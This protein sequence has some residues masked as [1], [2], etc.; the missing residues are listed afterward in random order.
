[1]ATKLCAGCL[2][3]KE[4]DRFHPNPAGWMQTAT[5]CRDCTKKRNRERY[6]KRV[7]NDYPP[8]FAIDWDA[9]EKRERKEKRN[10]RNRSSD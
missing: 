1:M 2:Q 8:T 9:E 7:K 10:V 4:L 6:E 5:Y 3:E